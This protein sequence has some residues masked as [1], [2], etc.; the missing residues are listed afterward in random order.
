MPGR[1][2]VMWGNGWYYFT[3]YVIVL[4]EAVLGEV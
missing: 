1:R 2:E 4:H 3:L